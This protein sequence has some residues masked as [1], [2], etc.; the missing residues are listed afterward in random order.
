MAYRIYVDES[1]THEGSRWLLIGMLF[2]PQH[3][4]LHN[5]LVQV[6]EQR[7]LLKAFFEVPC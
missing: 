1:D 3:G 4:L 7:E 5:A 6:K 2:V